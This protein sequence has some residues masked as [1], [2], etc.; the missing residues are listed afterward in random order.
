MFWVEKAF[1]HIVLL[2]EILEKIFLLAQSQLEIV[3][4]RM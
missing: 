3:Y 1:Q 2:I 4:H